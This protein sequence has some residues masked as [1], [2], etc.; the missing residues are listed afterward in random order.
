MLRVWV[1]DVTGFLNEHPGGKKV[2][3]KVAGKD[4]SKQF[5]QFHSPQVLDQYGPKLY[6]GEIGSAVATNIV[7]QVIKE[8]EAPVSQG[9]HEGEAFGD[10]IPFGGNTLY[11]KKFF[12]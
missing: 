11:E 1:Y 4:A 9:L 12:F 8:E 6:K 7:S 10:L 2:L 3:L 5:E